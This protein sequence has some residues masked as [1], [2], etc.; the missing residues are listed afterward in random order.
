VR[1]RHERA[2]GKI[3]F[4]QERQGNERDWRRGQEREK[5]HKQNRKGMMKRG[6]RECSE[7]KPEGGTEIAKNTKGK[8]KK[9]NHKVVQE[10]LRHTR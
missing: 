5:R 7:T 6:E 4:N 9:E 1:Q 10:I 8:H 2:R 3:K